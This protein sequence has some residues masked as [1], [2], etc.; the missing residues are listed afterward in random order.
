MF[1]PLE[2]VHTELLAIAM[3]KWVENFAKEPIKHPFL[4]M[5]AN[6]HSIANAQCEW[7][8]IIFITLIVIQ[9]S[10]F[11]KK[12]RSDFRIF[13][14]T[15]MFSKL[16]L[17]NWLRKS[18]LYLLSIVPAIDLTGARCKLSHRK[19]LETSSDR[20]KHGTAASDPAAG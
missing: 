13:Q 8:L 3:Q 16:L 9:L 2:S 20:G 18:N 11:L 5:P 19:D 15:I 7:I 10:K 4:A 1:N 12:Q 14:R 6:T 17:K